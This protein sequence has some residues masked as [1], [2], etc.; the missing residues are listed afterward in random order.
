[1]RVVLKVLD[2]GETECGSHAEV[3]V[4]RAGQKRREQEL[5]DREDLRGS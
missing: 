4:D 5:T 3:P 2:W 1:M